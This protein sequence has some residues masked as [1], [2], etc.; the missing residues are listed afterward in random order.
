MRIGRL[1]RFYDVKKQ[2]QKIC[3]LKTNMYPKNCVISMKRLFVCYRSQLNRG[4]ADEIEFDRPTQ[5]VV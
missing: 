2:V 4:A 3:L 5:V 1:F